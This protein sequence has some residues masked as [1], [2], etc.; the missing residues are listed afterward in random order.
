VPYSLRREE[1]G[2]RFEVPPKGERK[3]V[4]FGGHFGDDEH[5][6]WASLDVGPR[7]DLLAFLERF[8]PPYHASYAGLRASQISW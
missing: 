4:L 8:G 2:Y 7:F 6:F 3:K 5:V 1:S